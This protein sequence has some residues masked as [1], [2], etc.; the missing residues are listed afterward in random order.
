M[1]ARLAVALAPLALLVAGCPDGGGGANEEPD[2]DVAV[3]IQA[4]PIMGTAPLE[5]SFESVVTGGNGPLTYEWDLGNFTTSAFPHPV[6]VYETPG[7]YLARLTV[8]DADGDTRDASA[9]VVVGSDDVPA[10]VAAAGGSTQ[11]IAPLAVDFTCDA[12]GGNA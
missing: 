7:T 1:R 12:T 3:V 8:T 4:V 2:L 9:Q 6:I 11:G 10:A 5:V